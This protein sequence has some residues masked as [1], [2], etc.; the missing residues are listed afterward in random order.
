MLDSVN[1]LTGPDVPQ[2]YSQEVAIAVPDAGASCVLP[3]PR[4]VHGAQKGGWNRGATE[5]RAP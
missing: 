5:S 2:C 3:I 1:Y 4:D